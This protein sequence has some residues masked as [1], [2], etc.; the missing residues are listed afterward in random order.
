MINDEDRLAQP[1]CDRPPPIIDL[2]KQIAEWR[3]HM[4]RKLPPHVSKLRHILRRSVHTH[5][6]SALERWCQKHGPRIHPSR[7]PLLRDFLVTQFLDLKDLEPGARAR[8]RLYKLGQQDKRQMTN[9]YLTGI[10]SGQ[11]LQC[12]DCRWFVKAPNDGDLNDPH[13]DKS[14]VELGTKGVDV[15]CFGFTR[16]PCSSTLGGP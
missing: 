16:L 4:R 15:A 3:E 1:A 12:R 8:L 6:F 11:A 7:L 13:H 5:R 14:C 10:R 9:D 2:E